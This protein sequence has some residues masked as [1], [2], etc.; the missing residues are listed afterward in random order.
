LEETYVILNNLAPYTHDD[1]G[2]GQI[3]YNY[4]AEYQIPSAPGGIYGL[5]RQKITEN[6]TPVPTDRL[7]FDYSF[8]HNV[9]LPYGK[10]PVNRFTPGFEKTFLSKRFSF[11]MRFPF[12][13]TIDNTLH[14]NNANRLNVL[15]VGDAMT[16]IKYLAW[17]G[18][19][20]TITLGLGV[21]LPFAADSHMIDAA[22]GREVI[23]SKHQSVHLL[24]YVGF[25]YIP[26]ERVFFQ[27]YF[28]IDG[29]A[30]GDSVYVSDLSDPDGKRML[31]AGKTR[32][33]TYAY[34]SLSLGYWLFKN[35]D[36]HKNLTRGMN[37]VGELHW[38]QSLDRGAGVR[39]EQGNYI[40]DIGG[41]RGDYTVVNTTLGTRYL[42]NEKTN[43]G[44]GYSVP[45]SNKQRQFDGELRVTFNRYF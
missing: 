14:T 28:Q 17:S 26:N 30:N 16:T 11:E 43:I 34:T 44:I 8:F 12:A 21:S 18:E 36:Q 7:I 15:R 19:R 3:V 23:R 6:M 24:P 22:T 31:S 2:N 33:R 45:L 5:G 25:L 27:S 4:V 9:P 13:A 39:H 1:F 10:M 35:Y 40:F 41:N 37:L 42:F 29:D 32:E 20:S 38:T